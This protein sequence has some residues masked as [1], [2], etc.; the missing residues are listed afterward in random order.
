MKW[1]WKLGTLAGIGVY[2]HPTFFL[3]IVWIALGWNGSFL[4]GPGVYEMI[5]GFIVAMLAIVL[6]S[7]ATETQGEFRPI[8]AE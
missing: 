8:A 2:V 6:V 1:S 7:K 3:L 5:P 4:G